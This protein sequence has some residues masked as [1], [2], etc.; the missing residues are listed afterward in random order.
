[1]SLPLKNPMPMPAQP[2][3]ANSDSGS[4]VA[5]KLTG[6]QS[7]VQEQPQAVTVG[8]VITGGAPAQS[9]A[10]P[11]KGFETKPGRSGKVR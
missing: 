7:I 6:G 10:A 11:M 4:T 2:D 5:D 9:E 1:M 8:A 3:P